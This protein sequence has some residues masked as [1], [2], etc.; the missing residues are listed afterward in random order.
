[1]RYL[2]HKL[3]VILFLPISIYASDV[4]YCVEDDATGFNPKENFAVTRFIG[5][6]FKI[7]IDF[8]QNMVQSKDLFFLSHNDPK[9]T[10]YLNDLS[11]INALGVT[12]I[13]NKTTLKFYKSSMFSP[14]R[15]TDSVVIARGS[16]E[17]F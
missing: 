8:E 5:S 7:M 14:G 3:L 11:C 12:F 13:I 16:C 10:V 15:S 9:C 17:K 4:Y 6:K 2:Y 1:M